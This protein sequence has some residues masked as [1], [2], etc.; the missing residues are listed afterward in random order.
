MSLVFDEA[1]HR[2]SLDG[3]PVTGVTTII[4]KGLPKPGLPYWSARVVAEAAVDEA[5]TLAATI[6]M[7]GR[8]AVV[9]RL[10]RAPWQ[11]RDRAAVR[12]TRVH[13][14]A[15]QVALGGEVDVPASLVP[16]VEGYVEFL[17][18][19]DVEPIL[20]EARLA[21]RAHWYAGTADLVAR[22]GGETW[23]LDLKTSNNIHGS[24]AL[25]CAAYA[26]A[27]FHL[28]ADGEER[29][30]PPIDRIGAIHVQPDGCRLAEFPS[31]NQAWNA[32]LAVK[33]V[34][35]LTVTID[36]WGDKK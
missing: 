9:N 34:A 4:G 27:E 24:Y 6:G 22:M 26:R 18:G 2:Y 3:R 30:M 17:D 14:L 32:F 36:S 5:A 33:A 15:E 25:Q 8:D 21:S 11:A 1:R 19:H 12:G 29:P 35:D 7:Q 10:R 13:A 20:T 16:Y 28:D 31:V 23:L